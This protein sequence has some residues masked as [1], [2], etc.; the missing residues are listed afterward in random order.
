MISSNYQEISEE[1]QNVIAIDI[2]SV[3]MAQG[4]Y[5]FKISFIL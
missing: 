4:A 3:V 2:E 5:N 1:I